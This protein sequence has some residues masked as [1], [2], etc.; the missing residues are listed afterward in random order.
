M[1]NSEQKQMKMKDIAEAELK[2]LC[3][4]YEHDLQMA[5]EAKESVQ[6][7][8]KIKEKQVR[9]LG[10]VEINVAYSEPQSGIFLHFYDLLC[11]EMCV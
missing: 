3:C 5:K 2:V 7:D 9:V 1:K 11:I 4:D 6:L 8:M 10:F